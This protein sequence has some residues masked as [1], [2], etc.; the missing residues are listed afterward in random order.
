MNN[1][2]KWD[3]TIVVLASRRATFSERLCKLSGMLW[4]IE[5]SSRGD[6]ETR[7]LAADL[8]AEVARH[9]G[10]ANE[11][12]EITDAVLRV[13]RQLPLMREKMASWPEG[14]E[15]SEDELIASIHASNRSLPNLRRWF[16]FIHFVFRLSA[17]VLGLVFLPYPTV[18][19]GVRSLPQDLL[20]GGWTSFAWIALLWATRFPA[21]AASYW[22]CSALTLPNAVGTEVPWLIRVFRCASNRGKFFTNIGLLMAAGLAIA[23]WHTPVLVYL[24]VF[25]AMTV[26]MTVFTIIQ[27]PSIL[28]LS[29]SPDVDLKVLKKVIA[30]ALPHRVVVLLDEERFRPP[31]VLSPFDNLR[32]RNT[33]DWTEVVS[34]LTRVV[35][36]VVCDSRSASANVSREALMLHDA[37]PEKSVFLMGDLGERPATQS[38]GVMTHAVSKGKSLDVAA[39]AETRSVPLYR[40]PR[41]L[42]KLLFGPHGDGRP[43]SSPVSA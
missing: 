16:R 9:D 14:H 2:R 36:L 1:D 4:H 25:A 3:E 31:V 10:C 38:R 39:W 17:L 41:F 7:E 43:Y 27:K 42:A 15:R 26:V 13:A 5:A 32:V 8:A 34:H 22:F 11:V 29:S 19:H 20:Q 28:F 37:C 12:A 21:L 24:F 35:D 40:F 23:R 18:F 33:M 30:I 6:Q